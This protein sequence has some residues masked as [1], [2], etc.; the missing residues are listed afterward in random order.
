[1]AEG[2]SRAFEGRLE[3]DNRSLNING[4]GHVSGIATRMNM[5]QAPSH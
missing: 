5:Y 4:R 2:K 1:M 3:S